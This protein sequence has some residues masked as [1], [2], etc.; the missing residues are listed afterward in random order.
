MYLPPL[1]EPETPLD[2]RISERSSPTPER[3]EL[4]DADLDEWFQSSPEGVTG[5]GANGSDSMKK[6]PSSRTTAKQ[7]ERLLEQGLVRA[8]VAIAENQE[9]VFQRL[10]LETLAELGTSITWKG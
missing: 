1:A 6:A 8:L 10:C 5:P 3:P 9:D 7:R 4:D 2:V